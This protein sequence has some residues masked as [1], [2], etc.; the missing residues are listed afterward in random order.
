MRSFGSSWITAA[1][2]TKPFTLRRTN[3]ASKQT[4]SKS[5]TKLQLSLR[6]S[7]KRRVVGPGIG[8]RGQVHVTGE[9]GNAKSLFY[10]F[11]ARASKRSGTF[12]V[13]EHSERRANGTGSDRAPRFFGDLACKVSSILQS[14]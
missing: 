11:G 3:C 13:P 9:V 12:F 2:C 14:R 1:S 8:E 10:Y 7:S 5:S 4:C 6:N